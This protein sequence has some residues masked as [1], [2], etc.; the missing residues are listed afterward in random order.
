VDQP[1]ASTRHAG[2]GAGEQ[3]RQANR[4]VKQAYCVAENRFLRHAEQQQPE[5]APVPSLRQQ[6]EPRGAV[7]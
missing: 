6:L 4:L 3:P 7:Q 5:N 1:I 2:D